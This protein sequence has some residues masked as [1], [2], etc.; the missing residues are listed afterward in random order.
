MVN[1]HGLVSSV[2]SAVNPPMQVGVQISVGQHVA[3]DGNVKPRYATPGKFNGSIDGTVLTVTDVVEGD[4]MVG[5][6]I[7]DED[8]LIAPG[9]TISGLGN[10]IGG[11]GTY[12]VNIE[13]TVAHETMTTF[14]VLTA[15]VQ[16]MTWR[17]IQ[18]LDGLNLQ[19]TRKAIYL[20]GHVDGLVRNQNKGGDLI[21]LP[22]GSVWLVA[23]V[24]EDFSATSNWIKCA[25]TLQD[26]IAILPPEPSPQQSNAEPMG[27]P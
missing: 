26:D 10:G 15:Q 24:L 25:I 4:L 16:P 19:G 2:I 14:V 27:A 21:S 11:P 3:D 17:D 12:E 6:T 23:Q 1:M 9:T 13:Q 22:D 8:D 20:N 7:S 5:Q 18:M